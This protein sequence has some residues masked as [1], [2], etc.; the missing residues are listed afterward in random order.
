MET[1]RETAH[2]FW[3]SLALAERTVGDQANS[4]IHIQG[5]KKG[6]TIT[7]ET[8]RGGDG[9]AARITIRVTH[10]KQGGVQII[11]AVRF[12]GALVLEME[13][14]NSNCGVAGYYVVRGDK[15]DGKNPEFGW[16]GLGADV[17]LTGGLVFRSVK[18]ISLNG[19]LIVFPPSSAVCH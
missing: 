15:H 12:L 19:N 3:R 2:N 18:N 17:S 7:F 8:V 4:G 11:R 16:I 9:F 1:G 13:N 10:P 5:L 14:E 6:D